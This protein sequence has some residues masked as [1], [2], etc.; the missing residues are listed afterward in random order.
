MRSE[1]EEIVFDEKFDL[2]MRTD[3]AF[4]KRIFEKASAEVDE[5]S[6]Q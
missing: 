2:Q 5:F 1:N 6:H 4:A 3:L